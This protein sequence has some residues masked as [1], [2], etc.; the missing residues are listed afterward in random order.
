[1]G[2]QVLSG[3]FCP[4]RGVALV[5]GPGNHEVLWILVQ[6]DFPIPTAAVHRDEIAPGCTI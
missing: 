4:L 3:T 2:Q 5:V 6:P 1:M